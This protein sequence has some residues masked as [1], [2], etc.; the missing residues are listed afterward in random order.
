MLNYTDGVGKVLEEARK[1][2]EFYKINYIG[3]EELLFGILRTQKSYACAYLNKFG[4]NKETVVPYFKKTLRKIDGV[5]FTPNASAVIED[6]KNIARKLKISYVSTEHLLLA[7]IRN[8]E[9]K[10]VS[11]LNAIGVDIKSLYS[12]VQDKII[13]ILPKNSVKKQPVAVEKTKATVNTRTSS[14]K[15]ESSVKPQA[16]VSQ[17]ENDKTYFQNVYETGYKKPN[18][19]LSKL[20]GMGYDLTEKAKNGELDAVIG[21][22]AE[23]ERVITT[24]SRKTKNNPILIGEAGVGKSAVVEG[25]AQKIVS[26]IVPENLKNKIIFSLDLA[27]ILAGTKYRGEFEEKFKNAIDFAIS[28]KKI[29][30]FI[31]EIHNLVGA[32]NSQDSSMDAVEILKPLLSR[33]ELPI[34]GATTVKEYTKF[35]EKDGALERRFQPITVNEPTVDECIEILKGIKPSFE[36]HHKVRISND[37]IISAVKLSKRYVLGR[38]LPDKAIDLIDEASSKKR[39]QITVMPKTVTDAERKISN[40]KSE[41]DYLLDNGLTK[42]AEQKNNEIDELITYINQEKL[43]HNAKLSNLEPIITETE[44][45]ELISE[46]TNIP[47]GSLTEEETEKLKSLETE[48]NER[49]IGQEEAVTS[50]ARAIKRSRANLKDPNRPIGSFIFA[51][52]TGVGKT[53]LSKAVAELV[54]GDKNSLIRFDMSEYSDKTSVNK[55]IGA[56]AG[57]VGYEEEGLLTDKIRRN[58]YSVV[59]FDEIEKACPDIFDLL[60]QV[61]D[62]GRLTDGKGRTVNFNNAIIILTTNIGFNET[63]KKASV[64]FG[65]QESDKI[66]AV[67]E[68]LKKNFRPEFIN[69][70]DDII[71]FNELNFVNCLKIARLEMK[72]VLSRMNELGYV[73]KFDDSV[74]EFLVDKGYSKTYGA[75]PIKRAVQNYVE[76]MLSDAI[77]DNKIKKG[78]T[79]N[80]FVDG[81]VL[82]VK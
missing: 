51:G 16:S 64:G 37:A 68:S 55:L 11:I 44:I 8:Q 9:C 19:D 72:N 70:L 39:M 6:S 78:E 80:L 73:L 7:L 34:I 79:V 58:Q 52:P 12:Y 46:W 24:L 76:N 60:L 3:T 53:Q 25:L 81:N 20:K 57:Y 26:G 13:E 45:K 74:I 23:I 5:E 71:V 65:V 27:G 36:A 30:F 21:R 38:F 67:Y 4:V 54:F 49:V 56:P 77:I 1:V 41:R 22:E 59:L 10:A 50:V 35:I 82:N 66:D 63:D 69:R 48:L 17:V 29:I 31:D 15:A 18:L 62:E 61:L 47:V 14:I 33:G 42:K 43:K 28:S 75:R 32:G 2:K 40:L